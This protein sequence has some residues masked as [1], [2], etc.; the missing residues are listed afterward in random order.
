MDDTTVNPKQPKIVAF[1]IAQ[2]IRARPHGVIDLI[3]LTDVIAADAPPLRVRLVFYLE[4]YAESNTVEGVLSVRHKSAAEPTWSHPVKQTASDSMIR[5]RVIAPI[6]LPRTGA[7][8]AQFKVG[9]QTVERDLWI[10]IEPTPKDYPTDR[11][12]E[13]T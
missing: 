1:L 10:L 3:G 5:W 4:V 7:Y 12:R 8:V 9:D 13:S 11:M 6:R 2:D